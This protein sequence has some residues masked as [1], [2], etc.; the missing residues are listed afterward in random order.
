MSEEQNQEPEVLLENYGTTALPVPESTPIHCLTIIGQIEGHMILPQN[1]KTT[2]YEH[3][4]PQ[5]IA[6]EQDDDV[7]GVLVIL[8]TAGGDVE[9]GLAIAEAIRGLSKPTVSIVMG[10]GHSIGV[11]IAV[12]GDYSFIAPSATMTIHPVRLN[13]MV[14]GVPATMEYIERMQDRV[15]A[16]VTANSHIDDQTFRNLMLTVGELSQDIGTVI[17]GKKAV[18]C[19]LIDEVGSIRE[20]MKKLNELIAAREDDR[21]E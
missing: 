14:I 11:P 7:K 15:V 5:L 10:G 21:D 8:N 12:A 20:A 13:G 2:K 4:I 16:F 19:G 3:L 9:S 1:N 6:I 17:V 18:E